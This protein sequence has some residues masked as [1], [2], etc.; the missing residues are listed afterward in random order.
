MLSR[1]PTGPDHFFDDKQ[2]MIVII[3]LIQDTQV[4]DSP[5]AA[6]KVWKATKAYPV[7]QKLLG[8]I[9]KGWPYTKKNADN[10]IFTFMS[11]LN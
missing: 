10:Y 11:E 2:N 6:I 8:F 7:L 5:V 1:L 9:K 3:N 4:Q